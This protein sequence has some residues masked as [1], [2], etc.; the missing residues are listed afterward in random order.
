[1]TIQ[2]PM[3][4]VDCGDTAKLQYPVY[5]TPKLDGIRCMKVNGSIVSRNFKPIPNNHIRETLERELP[6]GA[7][8]EIC[9]RNTMAFHEVTSAV[10]RETGTPDFVYCMFD[11]FSPL[12][13]M[14]RMTLMR[15]CVGSGTNI[16]MP[17][18][19]VTIRN[20]TELLAYE[21]DMLALGYEGVMVRTGTGPYKFG[22]STVREGYL[23][24]VKRFTD[25]EAIILGFVERM[26]N[27]NEATKDAFGRTE[28]SS[29]KE[30]MVPMD[31]LGALQVRDI[32]S[33]V[34]F[35]VGTGFND[36]T[37]KEI[38]NNKV[39]LRGSLIKYKSQKSGEKDKPRFPVF[40]GFRSAND[41]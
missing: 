15:G 31:T 2:K 7:D 12:G 16:I 37:R 28:R 10:M 29:H 4:A 36:E 27:G 18:Y 8:G 25:S 32:K 30:N 41:M 33:G 35:E 6:E 19:P 20:E 3:L 40:L 21:T 34:E 9:L 13:Y 39:A 23:L 5:A 11:L 24:K 26:H 38:W 1:M 17:L 14:D 22:R